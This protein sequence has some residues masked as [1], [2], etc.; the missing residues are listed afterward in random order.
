MLCKKNTLVH[1]KDLLRQRLWSINGKVEER[2]PA[3]ITNCENVTESFRNWRSAPSCQHS[4][5]KEGMYAP[6]NAVRSPFL[7][8]KALVATVVPI[9]IA[10][11]PVQSIATPLG[12]LTPRANSRARLTPSVGASL[13]A[14]S[15]E[16]TLKMVD[17]RSGQLTNTSQKVPKRQ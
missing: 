17:G 3:L 4:T 14:G 12:I 16:S 2:G 9:R 13:Y 6:R 10:R 8:S 11:T 1:F 5:T 7:S 15:C